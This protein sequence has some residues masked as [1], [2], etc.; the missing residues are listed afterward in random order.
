MVKIEKKIMAF[1]ILALA[2]QMLF[3]QYAHAYGLGSDTSA[4]RSHLALA[5]L[6][7]PIIY[8]TNDIEETS[9]LPEADWKKPRKKIRV[10]ITA[11]SSTVD[12]CDGD[13]FTTANGKRVKDGIVAGNFLRFGTKIKIPE[14]YGDKIFSVEDR[15]NPRYDKRI[16]IWM[17]TREEAKKFGVKYVEIEIY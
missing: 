13:P 16:D 1:A 10:A 12:Q 14:L 15:M 11:Y 3:P 17:E 8:D 6:S 7:Q 2:G 5:N 9:R 4:E